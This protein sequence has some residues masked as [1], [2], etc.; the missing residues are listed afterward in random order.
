MVPPER[1]QHDHQ[2]DEAV[3]GEDA[4]APRP[5]SARQCEQA[6]ASPALSAVWKL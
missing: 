1:Q 3:Q 4:S 6:F 5:R 2:R